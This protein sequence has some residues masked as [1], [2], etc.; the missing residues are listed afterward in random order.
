MT[1]RHP[2]CA[3]IVACAVLLTVAGFLSGCSRNEPPPPPQAGPPGTVAP[4]AQTPA[5]EMQSR[6]Q[7]QAVPQMTAPQTPPQPATSLGA[8]AQV[9]LGMSSQHVLQ[10]LGSPTMVKPKG[11]YVEWEY[12]IGGGELEVTLQADQV[13]SIENL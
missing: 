7:Q 5:R 8:I 1:K 10:L 13:V 4:R 9:H 11:Q 6:P 2:A 12:W 3:S